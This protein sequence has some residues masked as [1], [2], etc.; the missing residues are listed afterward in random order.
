MT[1]SLVISA[2]VSNSVSFRFSLFS[3]YWTKIYFLFP[4]SS[5][6]NSMTAWAVVPEPAKKSKIIA[7]F[8]KPFIKYLINI[9]SFAGHNY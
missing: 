4:P 8:L 5:L 3:G 2:I 1:L 9:E 7:E 6:F